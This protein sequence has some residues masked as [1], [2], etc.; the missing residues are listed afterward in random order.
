MLSVPQPPEDRLVPLRQAVPELAVYRE[1]RS[2]QRAA[3]HLNRA[4]FAACVPCALV[5]AL[6]SR[7]LDVWCQERAA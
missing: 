4:G 5:I 3:G 6:R 2:W 1:L 7:G